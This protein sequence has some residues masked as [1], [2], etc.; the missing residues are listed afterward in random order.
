MARWSSQIR[1]HPRASRNSIEGEGNGAL[2][3]R[4][5][6]P[7]AG[8]RA[9]DACRRLPAQQLNIPLSAVIILAGERSRTKRIAVRGVSWEQV[10]QLVAV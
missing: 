4:L 8:G 6:A 1:V 10:R 2:K 5:T 7:P 9:N 3:I